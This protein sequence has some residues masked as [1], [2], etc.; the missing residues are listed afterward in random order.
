VTRGDELHQE[1]GRHLFTRQGSHDRAGFT[2]EHAT[3]DILVQFFGAFH[4]A[5]IFV[6]DGVVQINVRDLPS[7]QSSVRDT[8]PLQAK[9]LLCSRVEVLLQEVLCHL[10]ALT[11]GHLLA[12]K[13]VYSL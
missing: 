10:N 3:R 11:E 5:D 4:A 6:R 9:V 2:R 8:G 12:S 7:G 1:V 13:L